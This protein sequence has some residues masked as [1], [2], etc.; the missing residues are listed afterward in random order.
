MTNRTTSWTIVGAACLALLG[1]CDPVGPPAAQPPAPAPAI[2]GGV[3][4]EQR[5]E[6]VPGVDIWAGGRRPAPVSGME[7]D[8]AADP[9]RARRHEE[10]MQ[11][12]VPLEY[13]SRANPWP[14][15]REIVADGGVLYRAHCASCHGPAGQG[16]GEASRDLTPPPAFLAYLVERPR[17]VDEYLLWTIT[18]GGEKFGAGMPAYGQTLEERQIWWIVVYMRAGF[19]PLEQ[20]GTN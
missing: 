13:R 8:G 20:P 5:G 18:E 9:L 16:D 12:G 14:A 11:A 2:W 17:A 19:P 7:A 3:D 10:F 1:A 15:T 6:L 4:D